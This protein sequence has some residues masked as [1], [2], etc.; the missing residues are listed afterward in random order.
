MVFTQPFKIMSYTVPCLVPTDISAGI[1][2]SIF[3]LY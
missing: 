3:D 2:R 1:S